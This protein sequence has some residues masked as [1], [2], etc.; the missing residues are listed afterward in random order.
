MGLNTFHAGPLEE[1]STSPKLRDKVFEAAMPTIVSCVK[2]LEET[3][4]DKG[5]KAVND[6]NNPNVEA[7]KQKRNN[8]I[9]NL[10]NVFTTIY[11]FHNNKKDQK[12]R[13]VFREQARAY[14]L[15]EGLRN[16]TVFL[17]EKLMNFDEKSGNK[18]EIT[19]ILKKAYLRIFEKADKV[20]NTPKFHQLTREEYLEMK[21]RQK[22]EEAARNGTTPLRNGPDMDPKVNRV[23]K[24]TGHAAFRALKRAR[25]NKEPYPNAEE[26]S[27]NEEVAGGR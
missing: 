20:F 14:L 18:N 3:P 25:N 19:D 2:K 17:Y 1:K 26:G 11:R 12:W 5:I 13:D 7:S 10:A 24:G 22:A 16:I 6:R 23:L 8:F 21:E 9:L 27:E 15:Q 4:A